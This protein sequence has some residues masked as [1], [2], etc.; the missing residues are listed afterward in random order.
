MHRALSLI[1]PLLFAAPAHAACP[2]MQAMARFVPALLER[3]PATPFPGL[4]LADAR[5]A[6]ERLIAILAQPWGDVVGY[7][8]GLATA[9][10][11]QRFGATEPV[12]GAIFHGTLR[13]TSPARLP[14]RYGAAPVIEAGLLLRIRRAGIER[15]GD[16]PAAILGHLDQALPFIGLSDLVFAPPGPADLAQLVAINLGTRLGVVGAPVA[17]GADAEAARRLGAMTVGLATERGPLAEG[18]ADAAMG[19][20]LAAIAWLARD[21]ARDGRELRPG[22]FV[23]LGGLLAPVPAEAGRTYTLSLGGLPG[24]QPVVVTLE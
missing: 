18:R 22:E 6:Q 11:R 17:L 12:R 4:N 5:C 1:A 10:E 14:A 21:L 20:P 15:A 16:D 23:L 24:A 9:S 8:I 7:R 13:A 2:D 3:R 19:H